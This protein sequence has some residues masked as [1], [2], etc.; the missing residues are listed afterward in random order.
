[1]VKVL[2]LQTYKQLG[3]KCFTC[4]NKIVYDKELKPLDGEVFGTT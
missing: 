2:N 1:M 3:N 4:K